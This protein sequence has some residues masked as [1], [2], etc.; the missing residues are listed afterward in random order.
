MYYVHAHMEISGCNNLVVSGWYKVDNI[1]DLQHFLP[2][3]NLVRQVYGCRH[4]VTTLY[5]LMYL[6]KGYMALGL[7]KRWNME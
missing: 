5:E 1:M 4:L 7:R 2:C 6:F 3:Y